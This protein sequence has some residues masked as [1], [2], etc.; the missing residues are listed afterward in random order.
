M[1]TGIWQEGKRMMWI[2]EGD[3]S[4]GVTSGQMSSNAA[5]Y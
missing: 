4:E 3:A 5:K 2:D 1:R